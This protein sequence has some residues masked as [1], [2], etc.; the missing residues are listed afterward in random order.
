[1]LDLRLILCQALLDAIQFVLEP[2][3][4]LVSFL[5]HS[6]RLVNSPLARGNAPFKDGDPSVAFLTS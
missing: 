4:G 3:Y 5:D 2:V 1:M 6:K